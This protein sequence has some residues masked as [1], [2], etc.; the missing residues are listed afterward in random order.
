MSQRDIR[1]NFM[2]RYLKSIE[3][4][5]HVIVY[6]VMTFEQMMDIRTRNM[7]VKEHQEHV[8]A[9]DDGSAWW[10]DYRTII[11]YLIKDGEE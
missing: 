8:K 11:K 4:N 2:E 9:N 7:T 10:D 1:K 6:K 5:Y 3:A